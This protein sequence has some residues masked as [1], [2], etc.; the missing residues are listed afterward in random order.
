[1]CIQ[2]QNGVLHSLYMNALQKN[3]E[4][5]ITSNWDNFVTEMRAVK[6][7]EFILLRSWAC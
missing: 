2:K 4:N 3:I 7:S 1:M 5:F 6:W